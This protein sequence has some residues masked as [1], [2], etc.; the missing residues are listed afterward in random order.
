MHWRTG[1]FLLL[2]ST[3]TLLSACGG[4]SSDGGNSGGQNNASTTKIAL[5]KKLFFD[6]NLSSGKNQSCGDC[7]DPAAGFSDA[8]VAQSAPVSEGSVSGQFGN[9]NAPTAA[10]A[11][12]IPDFVKT[13]TTTD[14]GTVS[15][16]QGGQFLDGRAVDLI[17]Q[18]KGPF[19]NPKEMNNGDGLAGRTSVVDE[20]ASATYADDFLSVYGE[21]AFDD[22]DAAYHNIADAIAAFEQSD[23]LN[24]FSSKFDA[25]MAGGELF[26]ASEQRGFDIFTSKSG[27]TNGKC[28]N[29]HTVNDPPAG[30]LFTNFNYFN[31]GTPPNLQNPEN[32]SNPAFVDE[33]LAGNPTVISN[34]DEAAERG[35]FRTP[36]LRNIELTAPYMHNGRY[37]TLEDVINHYDIIVS[38]AEAGFSADDEYPEVDDNIATELNFGDPLFTAALGLSAQEAIDLKAFLLTLTDGYTP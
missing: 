13:P 26:S 29:C 38:S 6:Q 36:T 32:I 7:H 21:N 35:K 31:V 14:D 15:N 34:G 27:V 5:G 9:R 2:I 3:I 8:S 12:F 30:S 11:S 37:Q 18:A 25:V 23:E 16:Y 33:G 20:V 1:Y 24:P 28:G 4:G 17:E 10:Y 22:V 19:L